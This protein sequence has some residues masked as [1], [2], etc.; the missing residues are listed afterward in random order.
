MDNQK[1][2]ILFGHGSRDPEWAATLERIGRSVVR[3]APQ[4]RLA[5]AYL[6]FTAPS[7]PQAAARLIGEGCR[8]IAVVPVFLARGGH[9][10]HDLPMLMA[11][12]RQAHAQVD[13]EL[14]PPLGEVDSV[15]E[16]MAAHVLTLR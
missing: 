15:I 11:E 9:L 12:L 6:E 4:T 8:R 2:L 10:K 1:A 3:Q 5:T 13:F 7:L 16:A 14:S